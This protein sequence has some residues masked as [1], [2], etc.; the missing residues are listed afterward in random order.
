[1]LPKVYNYLFEYKYI[2]VIVAVCEIEK[3][4]E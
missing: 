2:H 4:W 3:I 1:M